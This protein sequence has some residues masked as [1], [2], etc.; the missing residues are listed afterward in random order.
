ME[1][2]PVGFREVAKKSSSLNGQAIKE[3][4]TF[5]NLLELEQNGQATKALPPPLELSDHRNFFSLFFCLKIAKNG[6]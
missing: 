2:K 5:L 4:I 1:I 6:F 3:K